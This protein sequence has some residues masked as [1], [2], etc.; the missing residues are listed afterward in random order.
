MAPLSSLLPIIK[1]APILERDPGR[2]PYAPPPQAGKAAPAK[3]STPAP[4]SNRPADANAAG[5]ASPVHDQ[6]ALPFQEEVALPTRDQTDIQVRSRPTQGDGQPGSERPPNQALPLAKSATYSSIGL[7]NP[8]L[9]SA[10]PLPTGLTRFSTTAT[11]LASITPKPTQADVP[12]QIRSTAPLIPGKPDLPVVLATALRNAISQSG[13]FYESHLEQWLNGA[14]PIEA[15]KLEPQ[16]A[17]PA[18][19]GFSAGEPGSPAVAQPQSAQPQPNLVQEPMAWL[20]QNLV[21]QLSLLS[22]PALAW[23]GQVWPGQNVLVQTSRDGAKS[24]DGEAPWVTRL[25][26]EMP[27]LGKVEIVISLD[28]RGVDLDIRGEAAAA[29][30]TMQ[31]RLA[32]LGSQLTDT[33]CNVRRM[34]IRSSREPT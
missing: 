3:D 20:Q 30:R 29:L 2:Q 25:N 16:A 12:A 22:N 17:L 11:L 33:G 24:V 6:L 26:L 32:D 10:A 18:I 21:Q 31:A 1:L 14:L 5:I 13:L 15:L 23:S 7:L 9:A 4:V 34:Q 8:K 19:L 28:N 27:R